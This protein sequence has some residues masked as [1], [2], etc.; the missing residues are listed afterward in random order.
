MIEHQ[1]HTYTLT[2]IIFLSTVG[3]S[4]LCGDGDI[5]LVNQINA[6]DGVVEICNQNQWSTVCGDYAWTDDTSGAITA[7]KQLGYS[8]TT[9]IPYD[10]YGYYGP[11]YISN[12]HCDARN[13][14]L[15]D[16]DH[17]TALSYCYRVA[18]VR[19]QGMSSAYI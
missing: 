8:N 12:V 16:C 18:A 11:T 13:S 4:L 14:R 1:M 3:D 19:C 9:G 2:K 6:M 5:R 7:C 17:N 15:I 10:Q